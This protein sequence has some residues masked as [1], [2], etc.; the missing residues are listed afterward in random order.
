MQLN[1]MTSIDDDVVPPGLPDSLRKKWLLERIDEVLS[2]FV[3]GDLAAAID[4]L[5]KDSESTTT[6]C[7]VR[8]CQD[9]R[10]Y[11]SMREDVSVSCRWHS[12]DAHFLNPAQ[13]GKHEKN[14]QSCRTRR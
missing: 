6:R 3:Y 13:R 1:D 12:C 4:N 9:D 10:A 2:T 8:R 14:T 7:T 11:C 5:H